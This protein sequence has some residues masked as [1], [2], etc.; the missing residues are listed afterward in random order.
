MK[1]IGLVWALLAG[2]MVTAV[3]AEDNK[4]PV[5]AGD[6]AHLSY[7]Q[8]EDIQVYTSVGFV[9]KRFI[10]TDTLASVEAGGE[11]TIENKIR[12]EEIVF[13]LGLP[14]R[15]GVILPGGG[16]GIYFGSEKTIDRSRLLYFFPTGRGYG[17]ATSQGRN[18]LQKVEYGGH[19]YTVIAP[20]RPY[21][22]AAIKEITSNDVVEINLSGSRIKEEIAPP[23]PPVEIGE[24]EETAPP[25][26]IAPPV[27][28]PVNIQEK[29]QT[30]IGEAEGMVRNGD[31]SWLKKNK[32][33]FTKSITGAKKLLKSK[34]T[35]AIDAAIGELEKLIAG[36]KN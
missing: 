25:E 12:G 15:V 30:V 10:P 24:P 34:D 35:A 6:L 21:L 19:V 13:T 36:A 7:K 14:G 26:E 11:L 31:K 33:P 17:L 23:P 1:R 16:L 9:L 29:L 8:K 20:G 32:K 5:T 4:R 28:P 3:F 18:K 27:T 2:V 22:L